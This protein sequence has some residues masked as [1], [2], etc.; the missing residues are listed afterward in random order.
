MVDPRLTKSRIL[1][2]EPSRAIPYTAKLDPNRAILRKDSED[3]R[4]TKSSTDSEEPRRK[5]P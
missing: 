1:R 4:C 5:T 2:L 3:E